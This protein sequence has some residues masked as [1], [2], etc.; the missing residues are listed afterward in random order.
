MLVPA[1]QPAAGR[2]LASATPEQPQVSCKTKLSRR[3]GK[4]VAGMGASQ[5]GVKSSAFREQGVALGDIQEQEQIQGPKKYLEDRRKASD[6]DSFG[7]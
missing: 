2:S 4:P 7:W 6:P 1:A 5:P 3:V